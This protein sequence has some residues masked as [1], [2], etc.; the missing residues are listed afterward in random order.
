MNTNSPRFVALPDRPVDPLLLGILRRVD[1]A[2]R[3]LGIDYFVGG[4]LARDLLLLHV[5]GRE[6]GRATRD[7]DLGI[8]VDDWA[9]FDALTSRLI[10][11]GEFAAQPGVIHRLLYRPEEGFL[12]VPLDLLPFGGVEQPGKTIA[13]PPGMDVVMNVSGF[14]EAH[15]SA[16]MVEIAEGF[17]VPVTSLPALAVLKLIAW[18]DRRW[19]TS[20]DAT[21]LLLIAR[22][23]ADAGNLERLYASEAGMLRAADFDPDLAGAMLLGKDA[24]EICVDDTWTAVSDIFTDA[25]IRGSLIDQLLGAT[26]STGDDATPVRVERFIQ[27]FA[28]GFRAASSGTGPNSR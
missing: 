22:H 25:S 14:A 17:S 12:G 3:A 7:V 10:E 15:A 21:D 1:G 13:W 4:A 11:S 9:G 27:A 19:E 16:L 6:T 24:A 18:R 26:L 2:A 23:Y 5:F 20:K 8:C 28:D